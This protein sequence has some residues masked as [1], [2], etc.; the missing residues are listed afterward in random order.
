MYY[1]DYNTF[2][3]ELFGVKVY[4]I[5]IDAGFSCPN[6]DGTVG[7]TGCIYCNNK[8]FSPSYRQGLK[9]IQEQIEVGMQ[10]GKK[11]KAKKFLAYFQPHT[12][13]HASV[14]ELEKIYR[15][16]LISPD[17]VGIVIGTRPDAVDSAKL[18][19]LEELSKEMFVSI[20]YG[21]QSISN[22]TL[23]WIQRGHTFESYLQAMEWTKNRNLHVCTHIMFG[24]PGEDREQILETVKILNEVQTN[25]VKLH[26]LL[27]VR[28]TLLASMYEQNPFKLL[29]FDEY[30]SL[31]CDFIERLNPN[32]ICERLYAITPAEYLIAP[33]WQRSP[34]QVVDA[35][36]VEF[37]RRGTKQGI[38]Y[39]KELA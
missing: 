2:L 15:S 31:I 25:G 19:L 33:Q 24:F 6:I 10:I 36:N 23:Q 4:K 29:S 26:N 38:F 1:R 28:D 32:V 27:I 22:K 8:S 12:N 7:T 13:T 3:R 35:V 30:V 11:Y 21:L 39:N 9:T 17:I 18:D 34:T 14:E 16:V 20:E 37:A 5:S